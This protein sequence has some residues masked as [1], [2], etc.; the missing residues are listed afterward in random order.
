MTSITAKIHQGRYDSE[1]ELINLRK[2]ALRLNNKQVLD[3][4]NQRLKKTYP[5]IYQRIVGPLHE[6]K[7][8][9]K[10][11]CYCNHPKSLH[12]IYLDIKTN[13][14]PY[15]SLTCDDC[16][17]KDISFTWGYYGWAK[18]LIPVATWEKLCRERGN[19]KFAA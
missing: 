18:K 9:K 14:V 11:K 10:F 12:D 3:A 16:W 7:R 8:D 13:S 15:D 1:K 4:V 19:D 2:N 17:D 6:R 5:K